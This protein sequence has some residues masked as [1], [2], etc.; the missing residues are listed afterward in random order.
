MALPLA[1]GAILMVAVMVLAF[2]VWRGGTPVGPRLTIT[3]A[4]SCATEAAPM[5]K[6][7]AEAIG[8]GDLIFDA[9]G[10]TITLTV[11]LPGKDPDQEREKLPRLLGQRGILSARVDETEVLIEAFTLENIGLQLDESGLGMAVVAL[12]SKQAKGLSRHVNDHPDDVV[13]L[14]LDD[15][16]V[17][18]R[19]NSA[20][21][22][23]NE[24][25]IIGEETAPIARMQSAA[26]Q[27]IVL[28]HGP[29]PCTLSV[30]DVS[31][32]S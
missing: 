20:L 8:L 2:L 1:F 23:S 7:R 15:V 9:A 31:D 17:A 21:I 18:R 10:E 24:L 11:T 4:G 29:L 5:V 27:V 6:H 12:D 13:E 22:S 16:V 19:P 14:L 3:L 26:D 30:E 32:A 25:R 28:R